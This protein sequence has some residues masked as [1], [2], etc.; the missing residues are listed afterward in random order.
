MIQCHDVN[1]I[2][3]LER[4]L[5]G[6][7]EIPYTIKNAV[8]LDIGANVGSFAVWINLVKSETWKNTKI[9]CYEPSSKNYTDLQMNIM[10]YNYKNITTINAGVSDKHSTN[11]RLWNGLNHCGEKSLYECGQQSTE[12]YELIN[13]IDAS[14]LPTANIV[15]INTNGSEIDILNRITFEPDVYLIEYYSNYIRQE[16]DKL[17]ENYVLYSCTVTSFGPDRVCRGL[18]KYIHMRCL[19]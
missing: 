14:T 17:M 12:D 8:I 6:V 11:V 5:N 4:I 16:I 9:Y 15:K 2:P 10:K 19:S 13:L 18:V 1:M 7:Y 3:H